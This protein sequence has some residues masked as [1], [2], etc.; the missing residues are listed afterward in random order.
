L[1]TRYFPSSPNISGQRKTII[2][3]DTVYYRLE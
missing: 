3:R 1:D 2:L